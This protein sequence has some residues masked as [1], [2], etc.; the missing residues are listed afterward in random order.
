MQKRMKKLIA[1]AMSAM[2]LVPGTAFAQ[3]NNARSSIPEFY[4]TSDGT[5]KYDLMVSSYKSGKQGTVF[6]QYEIRDFD[7]YDRNTQEDLIELKKYLRS[8][9]KIT[10]NA[11]TETISKGYQIGYSSKAHQQSNIVADYTITRIIGIHGFKCNG[12]NWSTNTF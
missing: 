12:A 7:D 5:Y 10:Y 1:L 9:A 2:L 4:V 8:D 11:T 6:T 3:E